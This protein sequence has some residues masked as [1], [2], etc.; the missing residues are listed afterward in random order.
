MNNKKYNI[1]STM[2]PCLIFSMVTGNNLFHIRK[3][4]NDNSVKIEFR[5]DRLICFILFYIILFAYQIHFLLPMLTLNSDRKIT[6][7]QSFAILQTIRLIFAISCLLCSA[8][9][10]QNIVKLLIDVHSFDVNM[11]QFGI[12]LDYKHLIKLITCFILYGVVCLLYFVISLIQALPHELLGCY[13]IEIFVLGYSQ[14]TYI[15]I[16]CIFV[17]LFLVLGDMIEKIFENL[18]RQFSGQLN[19]DELVNLILQ[20]RRF[21][22]TIYYASKLAGKYASGHIVLSFSLF[23][24]SETYHL[25]SILCYFFYG[26]TAFLLSTNIWFIFACTEKFI[27]LLAAYKCTNKV[28][29]E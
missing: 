17:S 16:S 2:K 12:I 21:Y 25:Y 13:G 23:F 14:L 11:T 18:A 26:S 27:V 24:A 1:L 8:M 19:N 15:A 4:N 5:K 9:N 22:E 28:G 29:C 20:T 6:F 7:R 3:T 10:R